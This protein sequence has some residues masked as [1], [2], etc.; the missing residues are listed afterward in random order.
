MAR[1]TPRGT[2]EYHFNHVAGCVIQKKSRVTGTLV[3]V[4][5]SG[6]AGLDDD[7][8]C[9]WMTVCEEH[10][11][12]VGHSSLKAAQSWSSD[13]CGWCHYCR[14]RKQTYILDEDPLSEAF[15]LDDFL[16]NNEDLGEG[17]KEDVVALGVGE[18]MKLGG[19]AAA[20]FTIK[21]VT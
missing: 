12:L 6:Q 18:S 10:H 13:P 4:Y 8:S 5:H 2:K 7:P 9:A 20:E 11:T 14:A 16:K 21:R 15:P 17:D 1:R 19:G 3:G